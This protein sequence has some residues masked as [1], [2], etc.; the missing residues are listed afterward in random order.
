[1]DGHE[2]SARLT[3]SR[4]EPLNHTPEIQVLKRNRTLPEEFAWP[5]KSKTQ[6]VY[7]H[8]IMQ[9]PAPNWL[10]KYGT[11]SPLHIR[12]VI[13]NIFLCLTCRGATSVPWDQENTLLRASPERTRIDQKTTRMRYIQVQKEP[14][15]S[16]NNPEEV[17]QVPRQIQK[18]PG[19]I[20]KQPGWGTYKFRKNP[21]QS[22]NNPKEVLQVTRQF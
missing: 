19:L 5:S 12:N 8:F 9:G 6:K 22:E 20:R 10:F 3:W 1:M 21:E 17:L 7:M 18:E 16:A 14:G 15:R 2:P 4:H 11:C 13:Y